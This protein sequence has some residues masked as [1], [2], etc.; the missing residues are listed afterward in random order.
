[1]TALIVVLLIA[2]ALLLAYALRLIFLEDRRRSADAAALDEA[3]NARYRTG[4]TKQQLDE[5]AAE[6]WD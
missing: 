3:I 6:R 4:M 2:S 1:M 5:L